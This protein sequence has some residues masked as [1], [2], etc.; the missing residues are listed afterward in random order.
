M[1]FLIVGFYKI[2]FMFYD[3]VDIFVCGIN[4]EIIVLCNWIFCIDVRVWIEFSYLIGM[5][6]MIFFM[7]VFVCF[8][9][10]YYK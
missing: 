3:L 4:V 9:F 8:G 6:V 5:C 1:E 2:F 10:D 7:F